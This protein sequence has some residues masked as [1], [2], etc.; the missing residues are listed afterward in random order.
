MTERM[1]GAAELDATRS[2]RHLDPRGP[3]AFPAGTYAVDPD[4]DSWGGGVLVSPAG[5]WLES[6]KGEL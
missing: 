2:L 6:N 5:S 4:S 1:K 3:S